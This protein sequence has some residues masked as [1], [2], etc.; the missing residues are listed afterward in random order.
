MMPEASLFGTEMLEEPV[1]ASEISHWI[2]RTVTPELVKDYRFIP[3]R[4][5]EGFSLVSITLHY[6]ALFLG[7]SPETLFF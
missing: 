2:S 5:E 1:P 3:M 4:P 7:P 6:L